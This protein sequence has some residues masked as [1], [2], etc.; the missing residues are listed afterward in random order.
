MALSEDEEFELLS[1]ERQKSQTVPRAG[2]RPTAANAGIGSFFASTLGAPADLATG[3][4]NIPGMVFGTAATALGRAD[5]APDTVRVPGGAEFYKNLLRS[6]GI[7]GLSPDNPNPQSKSG[8]AAYDLAARG[9]FIPGFV[10]PALGSMVA[11]K[12]GGPEW[13]GVGALTPS[14]ATSVF[15]AVRAPALAREQAQNQVRDATLRTAQDAGYVLPP[16]SIKPTAVGNVAES[17][18]GK[19]ALKQEAE[20]KNQ[21]VTNRLVREELRIPENA[22]LTQQTLEAVRTQAAE[23]YRQIAALSP[24]AGR[25][26]QRL[27]DVRAEANTYH[28]H[29]DVTATPDSLRQARAL[30]N[31]AEMLERLIERQATTAG[32]PELVAQLRDARTYIAKTWDVERA[33]NLGNG[34]VDA[35]IIGRAMD[36][37]R[38]L[39]GNLETIAR[40]AEGPGRLFSREASKVSNPGTSALNMTAAAVLGAE[41]AQHLGGYGAL[42]AGIPFARG[43]ARSAILSDTYQQNFNRPSYTPNVQPQGNLASILQQIGLS[44]INQSEQERR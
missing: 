34:N 13:A 2:S 36:R 30:D 9:G 15:N 26:L 37:G 14:A 16:S 23:P 8:T 3:L 40:F 17:F 38:P 10:L 39:S 7:P 25:A 31:Q 20:I 43:G 33:L 24:T 6:T 4:V 35:Q 18:A 32:R 21:Q 42:L 5:L 19:A 28:R 29:Y 27:R 44:A 41:G 22:P 11:E 12:I 1:L